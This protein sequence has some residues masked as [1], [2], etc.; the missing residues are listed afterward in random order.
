MTFNPAVYSTV[1]PNGYQP[2]LMPLKR[3]GHEFL[4]RLKEM[5]FDRLKLGDCPEAILV[6]SESFCLL[7]E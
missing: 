6:K 1:I 3:Q 5:W 7:R 4:N 2:F